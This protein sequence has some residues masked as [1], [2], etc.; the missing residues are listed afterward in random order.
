MATMK[1]V[2]FSALWSLLASCWLAVAQEEHLVLLPRRTLQGNPDCPISGNLNRQ[3]QSI[4]YYSGVFGPS[5]NV[6]FLARII[7]LQGTAG[8]DT[9]GRVVMSATYYSGQRTLFLGSSTNVRSRASYVQLESSGYGTFPGYL[10][11]QGSVEGATSV[12]VSHKSGLGSAW[13]T[14]TGSITSQANSVTMLSSGDLAVD[15]TITSASTATLHVTQDATAGNDAFV[16]G[17]VTAGDNISVRGHA[18]YVSG[19]LSSFGGNI[20]VDCNSPNSVVNG[21][22]QVYGLRNI[23]IGGSCSGASLCA[24]TLLGDGG[25]LFLG[26]TVRGQLSGIGSAPWCNECASNPCQNGGSCNENDFQLYTCSCPEGFQG[27]DCEVNIDDCPGNTCAN[28][29][30]C[31]DSD[32]SYTC[33]C[34]DGYEGVNC[35]VDIDECA[36]SPCLNGATC[37]DEVDGFSCICEE[38]FLGDLCETL[39]EFECRLP[40]FRCDSK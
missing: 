33:S 31:V 16:S 32:N 38:G 17:Q 36:S 34:L 14:S 11:I 19:R 9:C 5:D 26:E 30:T 15:G 39:E 29:S 22:L 6:F 7:S 18:V 40:M 13:L 20:T 4:I 27:S 10:S 28:N 37:V 2:T 24:A 12:S 1:F 3:T 35:E 25:S 23:Q 21:T 8:V